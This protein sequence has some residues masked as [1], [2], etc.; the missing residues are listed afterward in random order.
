MSDTAL[1]FTLLYLWQYYLYIS[2]CDFQS[3]KSPVELESLFSKF[4]CYITWLVI[5]PD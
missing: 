3:M 5:S 2:V 1:I 4:F